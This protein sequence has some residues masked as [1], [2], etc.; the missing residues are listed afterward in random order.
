M[1]L[2]NVYK[3]VPQACW[4][5]FVKV[6]VWITSHSCH[7]WLLHGW[8]RPE[9]VAYSR[10]VSVSKRYLCTRTWLKS[11]NGGSNKLRRSSRDDKSRAIF[12]D[13]LGGAIT[14]HETLRSSLCVAYLRVVDCWLPR[15]LAGAIEAEGISRR[16]IPRLM[17][18][19]ARGLS[20]RE[21]LLSIW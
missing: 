9:T 1:C 4:Y 8:Q 21:L 18:K 6:F 3:V 15:A 13:G 19:I 16:L 5:M 10:V 12:V 7:L 11:L 20:S 14:A 17:T 2:Q